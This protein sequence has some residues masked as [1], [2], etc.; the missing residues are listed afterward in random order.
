MHT[1]IHRFGDVSIGVVQKSA[2]AAK[3]AGTLAM[4]AGAAA[5]GGATIA[6]QLIMDMGESGAGSLARA[7]RVVGRVCPHSIGINMSNL[8]CKFDLIFYHMPLCSR[9][10]FGGLWRNMCSHCLM[11]M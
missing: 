10:Y 5:V 6:G 1:F 2:E 7:T 3:A 11:Q 9:I 8:V 4:A